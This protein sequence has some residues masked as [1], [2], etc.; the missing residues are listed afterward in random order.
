MRDVLEHAYYIAKKD[1]KEY[2]MK[3]GTISWGVLFPI[4]F[5]AAFLF[6]RGEYS[7]WAAPGLI[8]MTV[9]FSA[10]SMA[11]AAIVFERRIGSFERLLLFP[12]RYVS[13]ALGKSFGSFLFG[14]ITSLSTLLVVYVLLHAFPLNPALFTLSLLLAVLQSSSFGVLL[15]F[16]IKDPSQTMTVFNIVRF[17]MIFLSG[18]IIPINQLPPPLEALSYALPLTY[19]TE[20]IRYSYVGSYSVV[21]PVIASI[22][23]VVQT[24]AFLVV[25]SMLI[26]K[27]IP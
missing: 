10:T 4:T 8:A 15:A 20:L 5:A 12:T 6:R 26:R 19:S 24:L 9:L 11:G 27:S 18:V 3:P 1:L 14:L 16:A 13:I 21:P 22:A 7:V 25:T 23:M 2:Y 17:P